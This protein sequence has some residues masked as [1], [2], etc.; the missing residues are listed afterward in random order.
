[1]EFT[2]TITLGNDAMNTPGDVGNAL[3]DLA[4]VIGFGDDGPI[5]PGLKGLIRDDNGNTV[6]HWE[7]TEE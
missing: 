6:G 7:F 5:P 3:D 1:M 2:L 4:G